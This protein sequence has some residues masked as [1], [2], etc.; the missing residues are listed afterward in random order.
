MIVLIESKRESI[1]KR[2]SEHLGI[3]KGKCLSVPRGISED[4]TVMH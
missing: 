2:L 3:D 1:C 4:I